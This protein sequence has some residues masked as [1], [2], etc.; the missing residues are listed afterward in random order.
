MHTLSSG[1]RLRMR[2]RAQKNQF[3]NDG[4]QFVVHTYEFVF[5]KNQFHND[6]SQFVVHISEFVFQKNNFIMMDQILWSSFMN[7]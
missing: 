2:A 7:L 1:N 3:H 6:G 4:S 5:Q